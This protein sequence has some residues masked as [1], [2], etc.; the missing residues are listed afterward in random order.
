MIST[1]KRVLD[2]LGQNGLVVALES[3]VISHGL[4]GPDNIETAVECEDVITAEG[5]TAATIGIVAGVP[6]IGLSREE[7]RVFA[8]GQAP[9][10]SSI[11]KV[12][13][14]NLGI[15]AACKGWGATTVAGSIWIATLGGRAFDGAKR[16]LV[17]STGGIGGV[18]R[19]AEATLDISADLT[20]LAA[21]QIVCVCA[22]AKA[23][24]DL[25]RTRE[26][27]ETSGV[28]VI[29]FQTDE[30]PAFYSR[31]SGI[32]VDA[33][34]DS[35]AQAAEIAVAHWR[36]GGRGAVLLC[37]PV[38][39][40]VEVPSSTLGSVIA[41][42]LASAESKGLRGK[43]ITPFLLAEIS[44]GSGGA[45]LRANKALLVNNA[46]VAARVAVQMAGLLK[47]EERVKTK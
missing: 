36:C 8:E 37:V 16:P 31:R 40:G 35:A 47:S 39:E 29:G 4:P 12:S 32:P 11:E 13:L 15:V 22:G 10:G 9:D 18:H 1:T 21:A 3:T 43:A 27:L 23:I 20:A 19:G 42:S 7:L 25:S 5:A 38:P 30:F 24:L 2:A 46:A 41:A 34:V 33:T 17:F 26:A 28:P 44:R 14:N 45:T 6:T